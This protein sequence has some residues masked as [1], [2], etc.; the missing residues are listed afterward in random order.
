MG[1]AEG[2]KHKHNTWGRGININITHGE[3]DKHNTWGE[4][5]K[6]KHKTWGEG[7]KHNTWGEG[8]NITHGG[9]G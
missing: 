6:H 8:I 4:G 3:G 9:G 5:D 2:Y 7:D 1:G